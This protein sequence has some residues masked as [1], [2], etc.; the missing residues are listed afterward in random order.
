MTEKEFDKLTLQQQD[1]HHA[2]IRAEL[3]ERGV[4]VPKEDNDSSSAT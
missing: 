4:V 2:K 1:D 3:I